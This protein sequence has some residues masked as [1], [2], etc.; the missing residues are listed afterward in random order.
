[1]DATEEALASYRANPTTDKLVG[2]FL[3]YFETATTR[4]EHLTARVAAA[5]AEIKV[6]RA[7]GAPKPER[8]RLR[9]NSLPVPTARQGGE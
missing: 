4:I 1:M 7:A 8:P 3:R 2:C 9:P 6:L 5:E